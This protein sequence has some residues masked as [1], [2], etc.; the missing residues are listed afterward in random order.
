M[1][2]VN[3]KLASDTIELM[4][5]PLSSVLLMRNSIVPWI[6][7]VPRRLNI[8][9]WHELEAYDAIDLQYEISVVSRI[10]KEVFLAD[11]INIASLG[12][13]VSQLH[14][15][16]VVR[17]FNDISW[18]NPVWGDSKVFNSQSNGLKLNEIKDKIVVELSR[19]FNKNIM[20]KK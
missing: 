20:E 16:V 9:E 5:L 15:H 13:I 6:V 2:E 18:P 7:L 3:E 10:M 17:Y 19:C 14:V 12:N 1:F 8:V 4:E 11:K